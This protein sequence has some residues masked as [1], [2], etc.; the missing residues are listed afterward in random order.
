M[1]RVWACGRGASSKI[2]DGEAEGFRRSA[3]S[4][5]RHSGQENGVVYGQAVEMAA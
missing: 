4:L 5:L 1:L 3:G 2:A